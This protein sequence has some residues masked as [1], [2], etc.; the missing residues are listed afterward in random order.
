MYEKYIW[1][2]FEH[3]VSHKKS[4]LFRCV[5]ITWNSVVIYFGSPLDHDH[6]CFKNNSKLNIR[7]SH[8]IKKN[9]IAWDTV[10]KSESNILFCAA[11]LGQHIVYS[12]ARVVYGWWVLDI[13]LEE[14]QD[15]L[16]TWLILQYV[17]LL[18]GSLNENTSFSLLFQ[19]FRLFWL[20]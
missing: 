6:R 12:P 14:C 19:T 20:H 2:S 3:C 8:L 11:S 13:I 16:K 7:W 9:T 18:R 1:F 5:L 17:W 15:R 10:L 4:F